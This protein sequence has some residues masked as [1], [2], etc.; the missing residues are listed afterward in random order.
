MNNISIVLAWMSIIVSSIIIYR[1]LANMANVKFNT[2]HF[3]FYF[4]MTLIIEWASGFC[5]TALNTPW[6]LRQFISVIVGFVISFSWLRYIF[7]QSVY[8]SVV[9]TLC[10]VL[11]NILIGGL[12]YSVTMINLY[13]HIL[14]EISLSIVISVLSVIL[15]CVAAII[16]MR[17]EIG[18]NVRLRDSYVLIALLPIFL[19]IFIMQF[20]FDFN[21]VTINWYVP[22]FTVAAF[23]VSF[24]GWYSFQRMLLYI[25]RDR[26]NVR[27]I[28][29]ARVKDEL[30]RS[31]RHDLNNHLLVLEGLIDDGNAEAARGYIGDIRRRTD[32][33][34]IINTGYAA[35]DVLLT[36]KMATAKLADIEIEYDIRLHHTGINDFDLC[37]IFGN[38]ADNAINAA[39]RADTQPRWIRI[40]AGVRNQFLVIGAA[41]AYN[42]DEARNGT[43][44]G[45]PNIKTVAKKYNGTV[46]IAEDDNVF[47]ITVLLTLTR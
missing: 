23:I 32:R 42:G 18:R 8:L 6:Y 34:Q 2:L 21:N 5:F 12:L 40:K 45:I 16:F 39:S 47:N 38:I 10:V 35:L 33:H 4:I 46:E 37:T 1:L 36:D 15:T 19:I 7:K 26:M 44:M 11:L 22:V 43:G 20:L 30:T 17:I 25:E 27:Y 29:Q 41:N 31:F 14:D 28:E 13:V 9:S 24:A 3:V